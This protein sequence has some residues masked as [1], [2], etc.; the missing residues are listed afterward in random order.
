MGAAGSCDRLVRQTASAVP[1]LP[2]SSLSQRL[3]Y[4]GNGAVVSG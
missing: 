3:D 1:L 2:E 4:T